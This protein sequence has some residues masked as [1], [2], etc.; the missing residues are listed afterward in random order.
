MAVLCRGHVPIQAGSLLEAHEIR[1]ISWPFTG[2][3]PCTP[4]ELIN[5]GA[6]AKRPGHV[7]V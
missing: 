2:I 7:V 1:R 6:Y 5:S 3:V 4:E